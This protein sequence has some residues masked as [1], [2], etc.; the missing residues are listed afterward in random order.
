MRV[1][2]PALQEWEAAQKSCAAVSPATNIHPGIRVVVQQIGRTAIAP[3]AG[4]C[5]KSS[6]VRNCSGVFYQFLEERVRRSGVVCKTRV[7]KRSCGC[8]HHARWWSSAERWR[9]IIRWRERRRSSSTRDCANCSPRGSRSRPSGRFAGASG[10]DQTARHRGHLSRR[11]GDV[12]E[13]E[14]RRKIRA[15]I[16]RAIR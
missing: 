16:W 3:I 7:S 14:C 4:L 10:D 6:A 8:I 12:G 9:W 5:T 1:R 15:R 2:S 11:L 13:G